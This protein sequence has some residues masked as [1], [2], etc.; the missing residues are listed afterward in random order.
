MDLESNNNIVNTKNGMF[1]FTSTFGFDRKYRL[2]GP[3]F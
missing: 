3:S 2:M 1:I